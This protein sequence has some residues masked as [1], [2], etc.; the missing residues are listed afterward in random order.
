M[1]SLHGPIAKYYNGKELVKDR[2]DFH[3][4]YQYIHVKEVDFFIT[5][6]SLSTIVNNTNYKPYILTCLQPSKVDAE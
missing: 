6:I 2:E 5:V 1:R 3:V 4:S